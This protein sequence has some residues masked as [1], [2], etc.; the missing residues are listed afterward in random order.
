[1]T[2]TYSSY[3]VLAR[4]SRAPDF[5]LKA[6]DGKTYSLA[7][8]KGKKALLLI[9]MC[10]HCPYVVPK[11]DYF[12]ELQGGYSGE[13]LQV[14]AINS[15]DAVNYPEDSFDRMKDYVLKYGFNFPYLFDERQEVAKAYGA[16]CTPDPFLFD[17]DLK[18]A[19][20]GR[21]DDA[22][23]KSHAEGKTSEME[24]AIRQLLAGQQVTVESLPSFGCNIKWK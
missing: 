24:D 22:H 3:K 16:E 13:G 15:N 4:G 19:Y 18:M 2:L 5:R 8:F 23:G 17:S 7:D 12:V 20:H 11:M 10:N 9:F 1:M 6:T 14:V 21:F